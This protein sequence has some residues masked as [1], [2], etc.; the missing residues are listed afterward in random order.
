MDETQRTLWPNHPRPPLTR[1]AA[2]VVGAPLI[3]AA[4]LTG[5]AFLVAGSSLATREAVVAR[6]LEAAQAF[7]LFL[8]GFTLTA[9]LVGVLV[10]SALGMRGVLAWL[11][12]GAATG[13][14]ASAGLALAVGGAVQTM[15][16]TV[17]MTLGMTLFLLIR[18]LAGVRAG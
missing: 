12:T 2:A 8:P 6:T 18:G 13:A 17:A 16:L 15:Q 4:V 11:T 9:G 5:L 14:L 10:L 1:L 7:F 3:L